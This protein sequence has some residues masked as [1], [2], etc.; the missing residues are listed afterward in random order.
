M[1]VGHSKM[2][3]IQGGGGGGGE[4]EKSSGDM[5]VGEECVWV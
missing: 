4:G 1:R 5:A 2:V 3:M